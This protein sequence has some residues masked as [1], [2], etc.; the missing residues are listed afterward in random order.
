MKIRNP[1]IINGEILSRLAIDDGLYAIFEHIEREEFAYV[2]EILDGPNGHKIKNS[3]DI[4][5]FTLLMRAIESDNLVIVL[6]LLNMGSLVAM[7]RNGTDALIHA[8]N[9]GASPEIISSLF[10][11]GDKQAEGLSARFYNAMIK[12]KEEISVIM[13]SKPGFKSQFSGMYKPSALYATLA[14]AIFK[15]MPILCNRMYECRPHDVENAVYIYCL[16]E[17]EYGCAPKYEGQCQNFVSM[18]ISR[19]FV[20]M[21]LHMRAGLLSLLCLSY[22]ASKYSC[23]VE[24]PDLPTE[25]HVLAKIPVEC[26]VIID[27]FL[28]DVRVYK[29]RRQQI[30]ESYYLDRTIPESQY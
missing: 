26:F 7:S 18:A 14:L 11:W 30:P 28:C 15:D 4:D 1:I 5:G 25:H 20:P 24:H 8:Y 27:T 23:S 22:R 12:R 6:K 17:K 16:L 10:E 2:H 19:F 29:N 13:L 3:R 21:C 9:H